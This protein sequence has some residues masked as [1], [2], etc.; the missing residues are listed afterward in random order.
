M[1]TLTR[2]LGTGL[3]LASLAGCSNKDYLSPK[4]FE[5]AQWKYFYNGNGRIWSCYASENIQ[6]NLPNWRMY[7]SEVRKRNNNKLEGYILLP[8]LDYNGKVGK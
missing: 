1:K 2:I 8:D 4:D 6:K 3:M 7:E 5:N